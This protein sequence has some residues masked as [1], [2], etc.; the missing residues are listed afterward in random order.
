MGRG[1]LPGLAG[2]IALLVVAAFVPATLQAA[3]PGSVDEEIVE[4]FRQSI[5]AGY[6]ECNAEKILSLYHGDAQVATFTRGVLDKDSF[7]A[8]LREYIALNSAFAASLE[9]G[10]AT[11]EGDVALVPLRLTLEGTDHGGTRK[12]TSDR[13]YCRLKKQGTWKILMQ[14]YR[15]DYTLPPL[16]TAPGVHH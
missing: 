3:E 14:T 12:V 13:L 10:A 11:F 16:T 2:F 5:I 7:A 1:L 9:V 8:L 4:V 6:Q 15:R